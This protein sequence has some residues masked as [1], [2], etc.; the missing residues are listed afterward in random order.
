MST[1]P[2]RRPYNVHAARVGDRVTLD[3]PGHEP[4]ALIVHTV[5]APGTGGRAYYAGPG[6]SACIRPGGYGAPSVAGRR[7][8]ADVFPP[9]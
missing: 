7:H 5:S 2:A 1:A 4:L 8:A 9:G 3:R 6:V